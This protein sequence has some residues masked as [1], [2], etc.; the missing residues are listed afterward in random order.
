DMDMTFIIESVDD[1]QAMEELAKVSADERT[2]WAIYMMITGSYMESD[3]SGSGVNVDA[4]ISNFLM[5]EVNNIAGDVLKGVDINL[6]LDT[7]EAEGQTR[8]DL[9][10]SFSK[11]FYHDRIRV[12]AGGK[13]AMENQQQAESFLDNFAAEYLLDEAGAKTVKFFYDRNYDMLEG[14]IVQTGVGIV[15]RKKVL[16]LR[17]LFDFRRKKLQPVEEEPEEQLTDVEQK[18]TD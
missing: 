7:Y 18:Q 13:V 15:L 2:R 5:G 16:R 3:A 8:R 9:T 11:R 12:T 10:F 6:G 1:R 17:E 14:E 4:V